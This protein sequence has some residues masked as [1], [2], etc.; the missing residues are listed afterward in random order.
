MKSNNSKQGKSMDETTKDLFTCIWCIINL[1][2]FM[3]VFLVFAFGFRYKN[4]SIYNT[5]IMHYEQEEYEKALEEFKDIGTFFDS[6][7]WIMHI[8][9]KLNLQKATELLDNGQ[10]TEAKDI[11]EK[12]AISKYI[13]NDEQEY[14]QEY[15]KAMIKEANYQYA[16]ELYNQG[17]YNSALIIFMDNKGYKESNKYYMNALEK[18]LNYSQEMLYQQ[19]C[20]DYDNKNYESALDSFELLTRFNYENSKEMVEACKNMLKEN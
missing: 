6:M 4:R 19:A 20:V 8:E 12:V 3:V 1:V 7:T 16:I 2:L 14:I 5:A 13:T 18:A 9:T 17:D 10:Y 11:L 15:I